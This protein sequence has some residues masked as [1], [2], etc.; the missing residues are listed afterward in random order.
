MS[1][2][3]LKNSVFLDPKRIKNDDFSFMKPIGTIKKG[4]SSN[5]ILPELIRFFQ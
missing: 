4:Q 3:A 5:S 2:P 1:L